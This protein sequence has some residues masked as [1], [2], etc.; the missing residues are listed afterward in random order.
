MKS[1]NIRIMLRTSRRRLE[2]LDA[3]A[4]IEGIDRDQALNDAIFR[5]ALGR[6]DEAME[7]RL[8]EIF[9]GE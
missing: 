6:V 3:L 4:E 7:R 8:K 5:W 9:C 1:E 2:V